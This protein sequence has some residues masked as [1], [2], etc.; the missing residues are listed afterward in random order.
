MGKSVRAARGWMRA[1]AGLCALG[2]ATLAAAQ[3]LSH[4]PDPMFHD[5][6]EGITAGP[7]N[8]S[9]AARF[10]AQTTFGPTDADIAHLRSVGYQGWLN[11]QFA[12]TPTYEI[13]DQAGQTAYLNWVSGTLNEQVGQNNRFEA[14]LLGALGGPDPKNN[15][16]IHKDQLRQRVAFALSEIFVISDQN[17]TLGNNARGM[18]NYYDLLTKDAFLNYRQLLEEVTLSPAMGVYLNMLGNRRA[19]LY[20]N[21]H[22]DENYGREINQLFGVGL[23]M[24]NSDGTPQLSGGQPIATYVQGAIT[25]FA[26]VFTGWNW[27]DCDRQ[28]D[29]GTQIFTGRYYDYFL[30]CYTPYYD[31]QDFLTP[32]A[33]YETKPTDAQVVPYFDFDYHDNG[34]HQDDLHGKKLLDYGQSGNGVLADGGTAYSDL[35]FALDN[36]FNH[37][38]VG[39]FISRQLIQR[40]VT[41]NPSPAYVQR[42]AGIFNNNGS[43]V[44]GDLKAVVQAIL[45]DPEARYGQWHSSDT[46]GKLRE[47]LIVLTHFWRAMH[48]VH[49]CGQNVAAIGTPGTMGYSPPSSYATQPYRYGGYGTG[50][51]TNGTQYD[52]VA[53]AALDANTVFNFFKPSF[54]PAGEMTTLGL[55][56][57]EFQMQTDSIIAHI[58]NTLA[59]MTLYGNFDVNAAC[60]AG[61]TF[62]NIMIDH[63]QDNALAGTASG[64]AGDPA[65]ALVDAY[66][67]RFMSGQMSPFMRQNLLAYL[68]TIDS[69]WG[70]DWKQRRAMNAL[71]MILASPEYMIQK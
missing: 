19:D 11:E 69:S 2:A 66:N 40:L 8:D 16:I 42:V 64:G 71:Y 65:N 49:H 29:Y 6:F 12:A 59:G 1:F 45:L 52:G 51:N 28:W 34:L 61:D 14:W 54:I 46:F 44:R 9:D 68:N 70:A 25:N 53:Q 58:D 36:I 60:G 41:S 63:T 37:P 55:L 27:H 47:P 39:P 56:G 62:G 67:K 48:A 22:P 24:L 33:A 17:D 32:M 50:W 38:N 4:A 5:A 21:V 57:P 7:F 43:N 26:H 20:N 23:V 15:A 13:T 18:A 10:L 31:P 30:D 35:T 3:S